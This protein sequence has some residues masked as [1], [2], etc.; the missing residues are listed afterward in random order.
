M[1]AD[2]SKLKANTNAVINKEVDTP[3]HIRIEPGFPK[4]PRAAWGHADC[5]TLTVAQIRDFFSEFLYCLL[6]VYVLR[7]DKHLESGR[8]LW[9]IRPILNRE[10]SDMYICVCGDTQ[11]IILIFM[12][13]RKYSVHIFFKNFNEFL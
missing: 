9:R 2:L 4:I 6:S 5:C 10:Y 12:S 3:H 8:G 13:K 11:L 7:T 1:Q